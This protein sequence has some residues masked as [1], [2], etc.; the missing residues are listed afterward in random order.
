[1]DFGRRPR[2]V[3]GDLQRTLFM[4]GIEPAVDLSM[5]T[6]GFRGEPRPTAIGLL[7]AVLI[8]AGCGGDRFAVHGP[9]SLVPPV[10]EAVA[11]PLDRAE[12]AHREAKRAERAGSSDCVDRYYESA[13][14]AYAS[15]SSEPRKAQGLY[16]ESLSDCLRTAGR[17]GRIDPRS[18]LLI[19]GPRGSF[20]VPLVYH[21]FVWN[22]AEVK[23]L[24]DA[25]TAPKNP[26]QFRSYSRAGIGSAQVAARTNPQATPGDRFL[27]PESYFPATAILRPDLSAWLGHAGG[28]TRG[29]VLELVDPLRVRCIE[30]GGLQGPLAGDPDASLAFAAKVYNGRQYALIGFI[31]PS[32]E[33]NDA[34]LTFV[35]PFQRGKIPVVLIHGLLDNPFSFSDMIN[36]LR[37]RPGFLDHYQL[38]VYRYPTG[39]SFL[40]SALLMRQALR[41]TAATFDPEGL[42]P[43]MQ[44]TVLVGYSLGGLIAKLQITDS[45]D[46]LWALASD[47]PLDSLIVADEPKKLLRDVFFFEPS[48]FVRRV[49]FIATPHDG[50]GLA[51]TIV[52][53]I[54]ANLVQRL[55]DSQALVDR[56]LADN[57]GKIKPTLADLPTSVDLLARRG[58]ILET[59][60]K[61]P[62]NPFTPYHTIAGTSYVPVRIAQGDGIVPLASAHIEG[63]Q[64]E[65]FLPAVHTDIGHK[66]GTIDEI[67]RILRLHLTEIGANAVVAGRAA[68]SVDL[69]AGLYR[70]RKIKPGG[71]I[72]ADV[73][74]LRAGRTQRIHRDRGL[75]KTKCGGGRI[76]LRGPRRSMTPDEL[77]THGRSVESRIHGCSA[78]PRLLFLFFPE[79][80]TLSAESDRSWNR[81]TF[82]KGSHDVSSSL[83]SVYLRVLS[84]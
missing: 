58:P 17:F 7:V 83:M 68:D 62:I 34:K 67:D 27:Q 26:A 63:T 75:R 3:D 25:R 22:P 52:G 40:R 33:I 77:R 59:M 76:P 48:P 39:I 29:D 32:A 31:N 11:R 73:H 21:G 14:F 8:V 16:N 19:N 28:S 60:Q 43:G 24:I 65:L 23:R 69:L 6:E 42:D 54:A 2:T 45:G 71:L 81:E 55:S 44:N 82:K 46:A 5:S 50:S 53:R 80:A 51:T 10:G 57:P 35:E 18:R 74:R 36:S 30:A 13:V 84:P 49:I 72:H 15:L 1:M 78:R 70:G 20:V 61:L 56:L 37:T 12:V 64:S 4:R 41:D 66:V 79:P 47:D 38:A 9:R